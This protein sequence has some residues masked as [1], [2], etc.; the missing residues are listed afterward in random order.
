MPDVTGYC[1]MGCGLTLSLSDGGHITCSVVACPDH[2]AVDTILADPEVEH[3]V[4]FGERN[5]TVRHPLR[6][7]IADELF[8][9]ELHQHVAGLAGPPVQPG[10]YRARPSNGGWLWEPLAEQAT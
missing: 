3:V 4:Q 10:R 7:R 8:D 2:L 9:C 6:E 1:P 5:F